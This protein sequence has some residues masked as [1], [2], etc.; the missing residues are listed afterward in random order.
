M[1]DTLVPADPAWQAAAAAVLLAG[2]AAIWLT[3][4]RR[5]LARTLAV[6]VAVQALCLVGVAFVRAPQYEARYPAR[7]LAGRLAAHVPPGEP[8]FS[9]LGDY[10]FLIAFYLDRP[11]TPLASSSDLLKPL[12]TA[13]RLVLVDQ[14]DREVLGARGVQVLAEG[15]LGPKRIVLVR[16]D[17]R[18]G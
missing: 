14:G 10:D 13:S 12:R 5:Q 17:Q 2:A 6:I 3:W 9:L 8:L 11:I 16:V 7:E 18:G 1:V 15:R 4:R